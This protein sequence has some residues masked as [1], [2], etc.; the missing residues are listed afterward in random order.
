MGRAII[1]RQDKIDRYSFPQ[2][3]GCILWTGSKDRKGYGS[4]KERKKVYRA[5]RIAYSLVHGEIP[6][7]LNVCH[8]C[9]VPL[10][11]NV[12]H[13]FLGTQ[14]DNLRDMLSK[15]RGSKPP[16]TRDIPKELKIQIQE[17]SSGESLAKLA[18]KYGVSKTTIFNARGG[19]LLQQGK[20]YNNYISGWAKRLSS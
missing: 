15:Q 13:L 3:D 14:K 12:D 1:S 10:C 2:K 5:H 7:G 19:S 11:I 18:K 20:L 17:D 16:R 6:E 8:K 9:D 4:L